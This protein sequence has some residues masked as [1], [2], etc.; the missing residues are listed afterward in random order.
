MPVRVR[1]RAP[2]NVRNLRRLG[3]ASRLILRMIFD[4]VCIAA[5]ASL[6]A[7]HNELDQVILLNPTVF[8]LVPVWGV[9][10]YLLNFRPKPDLEE[11]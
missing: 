9:L 3:H 2:T 4:V 8:I 11:E 10:A 1:P 6:I 5:A 7:F